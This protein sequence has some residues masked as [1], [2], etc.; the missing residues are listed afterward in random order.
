[1]FISINSSKQNKNSL[2]KKQDTKRTKIPRKQKKKE[3]S[4]KIYRGYCKFKVRKEDLETK[5][6]RK[7]RKNKNKRN[8]G[9]WRFE[10]SRKIFLEWME[11]NIHRFN[12]KPIIQPDGSYIFEGIIKNVMLY[13]DTLP[14]AM[15]SLDYLEYYELYKD[16]VCFDLITIEYVL[17]ESFNPQKGYYDADNTTGNYIYYKT[18]EE[19]YE[20]QVFET[21]IKTVNELLIPGNALYLYG[22]KGFT[23]GEI[24][25]KDESKIRG[26]QEFI[27]DFSDEGCQKLY[28][29]GK[30][31]K[32]YK[33]D[34]L[35]LDEKPL[36]R[37]Q[38]RL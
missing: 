5:L 38:M 7:N 33:Y 37:Y 22:S 2:E 8:L 21:I 18:R 29:E 34:L 11:K 4:F 23:S 1:M 15:L 27:D 10:K 13:V 12:Y 16:D 19:L 36:V 28:L 3:N 6:V 25:A 9:Y 26:M 31:R 20:Q 35:A 24:E 30:A 17:I 32:V 14:E